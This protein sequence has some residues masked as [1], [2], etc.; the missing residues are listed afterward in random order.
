[1]KWQDVGV[2]AVGVMKA[3]RE[4]MHRQGAVAQ[5]VREDV[6]ILLAPAP[7]TTNGA[8]AYLKGAAVRLGLA[9]REDRTP[10]GV[11]HQE[12]TFQ[13]GGMVRVQYGSVA[14]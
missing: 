2:E 3:I 9:A 13:V 11:S 1:M 5:E 14:L 12:P 7:R 4:E 8:R 6:I 10:E